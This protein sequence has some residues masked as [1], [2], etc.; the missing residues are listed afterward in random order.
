MTDIVVRELD[1]SVTT[2]EIFRK[3]CVYPDF[4]F[5]DSSLTGDA[6]SKFSFFGTEPFLT[7]KSTGLDVVIEDECGEKENRGDPFDQ[8]GILVGKYKIEVPASLSGTTKF[9]FIGG[10]VGYLS[11]DLGRHIEKLPDTTIKDIEFPEMYF[12]FYDT[13]AAFDHSTNKCFVISSNLRDCKS[14][15]NNPDSLSELNGKIDRFID[16]L[17]TEPGNQLPEQNSDVEVTDDNV[18]INSNFTRDEYIAAIRKAKEYILSGD[19]YQ[20]N[21]SQRFKIRTKFTPF[22][23]YERLRSFNP[24]PYSSFISF[25]GRYIM[26]SSPERFISVH[27]NGNGDNGEHKLNVQTRPIKGTRPR[28]NDKIED[29]RLGRELMESAKDDAELTMIVDLE[30]NDLGRVCEY[31]TVKVAERKVLES[32]TT[33]HH[34]VATVEGVLKGEHNIIDLLKASFPGG[35]ITGAPKIRAMEII[36]EL[37]KT[38]RSVYTGAIGYIGFDGNVD[39]SVAIRTLLMEDDMVYFQVGGGIVADSDPENEY[40]ETLHK[41]S[42]LIKA[43]EAV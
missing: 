13:I 31:G 3:L 33:V 21:I 25:D 24:A 29:Q 12:G 6:Y 28:S 23:L 7:I 36:D 1:F 8:L 38:K 11:Y 20:V 19:I 43:V 42:A 34:L 15:N 9:P 5:L 40:E 32:Y 18:K 2:L 10:A 16:I 4:F 26:S 37:E 41:A 30:R 35:S 17:K 14:E 27:V 22:N 39:L